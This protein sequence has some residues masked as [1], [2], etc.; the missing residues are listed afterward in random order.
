MNNPSI[1]PPG[2][3][4]VAYLRDSGGDD[5]DLSVEQ[6]EA[7]IRA[8]CA[9]NSYTLTQ[10]FKDTRSGTS[11]VG[12]TGFEAMI[13][14]FFQKK[15]APEAGIV[16][17]RYNRF[18]RDIDDAQYFKAGLR[19]RGYIIHS[20][21]DPIPEGITGRAIE[22][23]YDWMADKFSEDLSVEVKRG[24]HHLL[25]QH[26]ALG[27]FPPRGLKREP[28]D[29]GVRRNGSRHVVHRW[30]PDPD[31]W[32]TCRLAWQMRAAGA[33]YREI[34]EKTRLFGS[35]NSY[36]DF[37][38]NRIYLGELHYEDIV[39]P[40]YVEPLIDQKTWDAVQ[41][42]SVR[43]AKRTGADNPDAMS[44]SRSSFLL[45]G[46]L[47]CLHDDTIMHGEV[48][49]F[50]GQPGYNYYVCRRGRQFMD[51]PN[52]RITKNQLEEHIIDQ[53]VEHI[54]SP[55]RLSLVQDEQF[56][57]RQ[58]SLDELHAQRGELAARLAKVRASLKRI[59]TAIEEAGHSAT[60]LARLRDLENQE[61]LLKADLNQLDS[62]INSPHVDFTPER[63]DR[64]SRNLST[65]LHHANLETKRRI[66][67]GLIDHITI[68]R[69]GRRVHGVIYFY[70][71]D[72]DLVNSITDLT[73][74]DDLTMIDDGHDPP[75]AI[76]AYLGSPCGGIRKIPK[77]F[78]I[79]YYATYCDVAHRNA[80]MA[81]TWAKTPCSLRWFTTVQTASQIRDAMREMTSLVEH[82]SECTCPLLA[83]AP[84]HALWP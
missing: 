57:T 16:L 62:K 46:L 41:E 22:F 8:W 17:W 37:Y 61:I 48:V 5:Q 47:R 15:S 55:D 51:C 24:L 1:F 18:A 14:Y 76:Y 78:G 64:F 68:A 50:K 11:T 79:F 4:L 9:E 84:I 73:G 59:T 42:I 39:I 77:K 49:Q 19:R 12:R 74:L 60:L 26:G 81:F 66:L 43:H 29:L 75:T 71:P 36:S 44:R 72:P 7:V 65:L 56:Q 53:V 6:Q 40:N 20:L 33:S 3:H 2:S 21:Q 10:I 23:F 82:T 67:R 52:K 13:R 58:A 34:H 28:V 69:D 27:G 30:V 31:L 80:W 54:L 38:K 35:L 45:S 63:L 25:E 70:E 32:A 83:R